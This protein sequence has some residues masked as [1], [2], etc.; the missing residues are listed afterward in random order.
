MVGDVAGLD[1]VRRQQRLLERALE[2][3]AALVVGEVQ[4]PVRVH[5]ADAQRVVVAPDH[6]LLGGDGLDPVD[7]VLA[8]AGT[9]AVLAAEGLGDRL[10]GHVGGAGVELEGVPDDLHVVGVLEAASA[11]SR[12]RLPMKH[13]GQTTSDQMS[14]RMSV[15]NG[16]GPPD[17]PG[18]P[19]RR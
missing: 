14:M 18:G 5:G 9:A 17:V 11:V 6:A 16:D 4:E 7:H 1:E 19:S 8:G 13:Q 10:D 12:R 2:G 3:G 15:R